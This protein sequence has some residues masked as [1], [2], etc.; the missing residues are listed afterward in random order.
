MSFYSSMSF[1]LSMSFYF[2][3]RLQ[4]KSATFPQRYGAMVSIHMLVHLSLNGPMHVLVSV[5]VS[6]FSKLLS[7]ILQTTSNKP[8]KPFS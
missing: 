8:P 4:D 6:I 5:M 1:Y 3:N 7:V 2:L